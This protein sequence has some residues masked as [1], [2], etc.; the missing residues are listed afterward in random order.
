MKKTPLWQAHC[1][2]GAKMVDFAGWSMPV[3]YSSILEEH[4]AVREKVGIFDISHMGEIEVKGP[5]AME[6][7]Q[8]LV[9][10]DLSRLEDDNALYSALLNDNGGIIDDILIYKISGQ[11]F[12]LCVNASNAS[13]DYKWIA[14][15]ATSFPDVEVANLSRDFGMLSI[16]GPNAEPLLKQIVPY[17]LEKLG[18]YQFATTTI[19]ETSV[20]IART[21]Y[22]GEDGFELFI[23]WQSTAAIWERIF[24]RGKPFGLKPIGLGA[25]DT[26]RL[27][28]RYPLHGH[29]INETTTPYDAGLGW[30]V[31]LDKGEFIG[32]EALVKQK[33]E[34][35]K[36]KLVGMELL[37]RGIPREG[38]N[39]IHNGEQVGVF[40]SGT[41]SPTLNKSIGLAFVP[42]ELSAVGTQ[43]LV[44]IRGRHAQAVVC[45]TPFV[46]PKVRRKPAGE[47]VTEPQSAPVNQ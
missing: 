23:N 45:K 26:L 16:Q 10:G 34:G 44:D 31:K 38:F 21:G 18:Y 7:L 25:R 12:F 1:A 15:H 39:V 8:W 40:T 35:L 27:E 2:L 17:P 19:D 9:P 29:E 4:K 41:L 22:T 3:Q 11:R 37:D 24:S 36:R 30:I 42:V 5:G 6:F 46:Q 13:K 20:I 28:M 32:K 43:L 33:A 47:A 14:G